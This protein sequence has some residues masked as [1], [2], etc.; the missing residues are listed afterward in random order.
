MDFSYQMTQVLK[1]LN[2]GKVAERKKTVLHLADLLQNDDFIDFDWD[3]ETHWSLYDVLLE[4]ILEV[5]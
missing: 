1:C 4:F 3:A 2:S 5:I